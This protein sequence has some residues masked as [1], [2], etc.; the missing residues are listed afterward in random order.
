MHTSLTSTAF[1]SSV[2]SFRRIACR[3]LRA[4]LAS[5]HRLP[6]PRQYMRASTMAAKCIPSKLAQYIPSSSPTPPLPPSQTTTTTTYLTRPACL[7]FPRDSISPERKHLHLNLH[8]VS[9]CYTHF[10]VPVNDPNIRSF[11]LTTGRQTRMSSSWSSV[12]AC[13]LRILLQTLTAVPGSS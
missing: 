4:C 9:Y 2:A 10:P 12:P 6:V 13:P 11:T 7:W 8:A 3:H 1:S 5:T